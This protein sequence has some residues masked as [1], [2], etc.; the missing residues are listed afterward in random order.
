MEKRSSE[1]GNVLFLI[2]IA[3][4]LFAALSFAV[5]QS[6]RSGGDDISKD[7]V[8]IAAAQ[9]TQYGTMIEN[10]IVRLRVTNGCT[11]TDISFDNPIVAGYAHTPPQPDK[12]KVFHPSGGGVSWQTPDPDWEGDNVGAPLSM[13]FNGAHC[14]QNVGTGGATCDTDG[15]NVNEELIMFINDISDAICMEINDRLGIS[16][17]GGAP[18]VTSGIVNVNAGFNGTYFNV[19]EI[20]DGAGTFTGQYSGCFDFFGA[21]NSYYH[22]LIAR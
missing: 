12:C 18:P 13:T 1:R 6:T 8:R 5:T 14:I 19:F 2:L 21:I 15:S 11:D 3:V 9:I 10:A 7:N 22:V 16:N 4:V 20:T 17:P